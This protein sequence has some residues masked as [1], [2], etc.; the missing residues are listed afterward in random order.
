MSQTGRA[1]PSFLGVGWSFPPTFGPGGGEVAMAT[2]ADDVHQA[3]RILFATRWG[4]R[5]MAE[6]FGCNLDEHVFGEADHA[7]VSNIKSSIQDAVLA[8]ETR[9]KLHGVSVTSGSS[10][11][12]V[13]RITL[14]YSVLGTNSRFNMVFPFYL[15]EAFTPVR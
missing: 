11:A 1:A 13:L 12:G 6:S 9:I 8:H 2:G 3:L 14:D 7:L 5:P 15:T 10:D 4:E